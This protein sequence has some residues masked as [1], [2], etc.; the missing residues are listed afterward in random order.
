[1]SNPIIDSIVA[2]G[3]HGLT[4]REIRK[5]SKKITE[6]PEKYRE[7]FDTFEEYQDAIHAMLNSY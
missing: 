7:Y 4:Y 3:K 6:V 5:S 2:S 1:M